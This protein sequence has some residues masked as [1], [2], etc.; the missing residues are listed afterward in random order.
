MGKNSAI[1]SERAKG[2]NCSL[3]GSLKE[4]AGYRMDRA[5]EM[6]VAARENLEIGQ[7]KTSLNRSYYAIFHAM[8]AMNILKGFDSSKLRELLLFLIR[9]IS[10]KIF[11]IGI[12][13][14]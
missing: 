6:L 5:K 11:S 12:Y 4:L 2:G 13:L 3:E 14:S 1:L 7:Y 8:R 9:S 10:K